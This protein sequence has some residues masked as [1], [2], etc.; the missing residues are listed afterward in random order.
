MDRRAF[1]ASMAAPLIAT[2]SGSV[3]SATRCR[4]T[5]FGEA[6]RTQID[7]GRFGE[8]Y[9]A[10]RASQWCWAA[11]ISMIFA[12]YG[13]PVS[14]ERIVADVYGGIVNLPAGSGLVIASQLNRNWR[15]DYGRPF[16]SRVTAAY[17]FDAR[18]IA[19][20][21]ATIVRELDRARPMVV[22]TV[23][24][25]VVATAV[26]YLSTPFGPNI[27]AVG[28]FDPFPGIGARALSPA[29]IVPM[30]MGGGLRFVA[31]VNVR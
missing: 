13:R 16:S 31:T 29:E 27:T 2:G 1:I 19:L 14:Q 24:H 11:S 9:A 5:P 22:G 26:D 4:L 23:N 17:D 10:Q 21:N 7:F 3:E 25:A 30:H 28:V 15:D 8:I 20:D 12:Y 6:C 18:V